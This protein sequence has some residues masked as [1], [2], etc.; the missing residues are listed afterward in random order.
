MALTGCKT[1]SYPYMFQLIKITSNSTRLGGYW[2][3]VSAGWAGLRNA[4]FST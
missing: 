4:F 2:R 1:N 3:N